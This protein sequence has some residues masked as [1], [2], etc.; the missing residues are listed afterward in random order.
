[1]CM[2]VCICACMSWHGCCVWYYYVIISLSLQ[3]NL[4]QDHVVIISLLSLQHCKT[5]LVDKSSTTWY[6]TWLSGYRVEWNWPLIWKDKLYL[7]KIIWSSIIMKFR[8]I[9]MYLYIFVRVFFCYLMLVHLKY[10][11]FENSSK[12]K[13][14]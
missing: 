7:P 2:C 11:K 13:F 3:Q 8:I 5:L 4:L 9:S 1:M 14:K 6:L 10:I 12:Y